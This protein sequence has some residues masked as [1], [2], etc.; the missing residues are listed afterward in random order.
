MKE[1]Y[2][3]YYFF[4]YFSEILA[5]HLNDQDIWHFT[6]DSDM[7]KTIKH[8]WHTRVYACACVVSKFNIQYADITKDN[9]DTYT[10]ANLN[11]TNSDE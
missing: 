2:Y 7:I 3:Y 5:L 8:L 11:D 6:A 4:S 10:L 1:P 9:V